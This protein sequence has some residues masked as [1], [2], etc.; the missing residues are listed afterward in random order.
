MAAGKMVTLAIQPYEK[1]VILKNILEQEGIKVAIEN[2]NQRQPLISSG[3]RIRIEESDL[4]KAMTL[5]DVEM[6]APVCGRGKST[7]REDE[8]S[9]VLIPVDFSEYSMKAC[10]VGFNYAKKH[11]LRVVVLHSYISQYYSGTLPFGK[12]FR[13]EKGILERAKEKGARSEELMRAFKEKVSGY[14]SSGGLPDVPYDCEVMEGIPENVILEYAKNKKP[15]LIV[16]GTRGKHKKEQDLIGSVTAEVLDSVKFPMLV[17]PEGIMATDVDEM[18]N[19]A[20]YTNLEQSDLLSLDVFMRN[21]DCQN[22]SVSV[23]HVSNKREKFVSARFDALVEYCESQYPNST[24]FK[25]QLFEEEHFLDKF[26]EFLINSKIDIVVI[27]N[28]RRNIFTR[29]FNP[30]L[31]HRMLFHTDIPMLVVPI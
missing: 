18:A 25:K 27:P 22:K 24:L 20:F 16:M 23:I 3:V 26:E 10:F 12:A 14:I 2:V 4:P 30:S 8:K 29:L 13:A 19:I 1:A 11:H 17:I 28:K 21:F 9:V 7:D 15:D 6:S 5:V 31:A